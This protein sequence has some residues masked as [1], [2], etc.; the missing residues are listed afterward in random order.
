MLFKLHVSLF[1]QRKSD[2]SYCWSSIS[3]ADLRNEDE[4]R[5]CF[6]RLILYVMRYWGTIRFFNAIYNDNSR[7]SWFL[8][9]FLKYFQCAGDSAQA[10]GN[11]PLFCICD[12]NICRRYCRAVAG[13]C[14]NTERRDLVRSS[15]S[16]YYHSM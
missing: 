1:F 4:V 11:F 3:G 9:N 6:T 12:K 14:K 16:V 7:L 2:S 5:S 8:Q 13:W 10:H 15:C